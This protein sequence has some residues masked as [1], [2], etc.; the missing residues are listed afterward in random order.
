MNTERDPDTGRFLRNQTDP[1]HP[2]A[3]YLP[4]RPLRDGRSDGRQSYNPHINFRVPAI[5]YDKARALAERRG[6]SLTHLMLEA[7]FLVLEPGLQPGTQGENS[8]LNPGVET[9]PQTVHFGQPIKRDRL[10]DRIKSDV[11]DPI[12]S[13]DHM[14][15]WERK[16][17]EKAQGFVGG[18]VDR[19]RR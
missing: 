18:L 10:A 14:G 12:A 19:P 11:A 13:F 6:V 3:A 1:E 17:K 16:Q 4:P 15:R 9:R 2:F 8:T 5:V 7:L